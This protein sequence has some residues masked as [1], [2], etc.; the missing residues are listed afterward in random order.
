MTPRK[1]RKKIP[2]L[3]PTTT[4]DDTGSIDAVVVSRVPF[5]DQTS[6]LELA[7]ESLQEVL[8]KEPLG[9]VEEEGTITRMGKNTEL[10]WDVMTI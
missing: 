7:K 4:S 5:L 1:N 8:N 10:P 2:T 3:L 9:I 6:T